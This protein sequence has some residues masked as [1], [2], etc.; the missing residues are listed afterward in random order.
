[1]THISIKVINKLSNTNILSRSW[2]QLRNMM[3]QSKWLTIF[4][5]HL[6]TV[7]RRTW[8]TLPPVAVDTVLKRLVVSQRRRLAERSAPRSAQLRTHL[9][10][11]NGVS[12]RQA[13][14]CSEPPPHTHTLLCNIRHI[15][16]DGERNSLTES[17]W[18]NMFTSFGLCCGPNDSFWGSPDV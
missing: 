17:L 13:S 7:R 1:M 10:S 11:E 14:T 5:A 16:S 6:I 4:F 9:N 15:V 12:W 2:S 8:Q 3:I 18:S